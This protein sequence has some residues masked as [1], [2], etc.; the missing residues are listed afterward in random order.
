MNEIRLR[1]VVV[2][3]GDP[4]PSVS[5]AHGGF[6]SWF[7]RSL[8][9]EVE[10][11]LCDAR[12][13]TP[14][15]AWLDGCTGLVL[16]GSPH[17][18]YEPLPW[19]AP[20]EELL[21]DAVLSR[22]MPTLGVC[23]GHQLLA[24]AL[25]GRVIRNPR[26]REMGT[27]MVQRHDDVAVLLDGLGSRFA[28]QAT[29]RDTVVAPPRDAVVHAYS[30]RDDCQAFSVGTA[31]GVQFHPE[32]TAPILR[33]YIQARA[34]VLRTEGVDPQDLH[35]AVHDTVSGPI[36]FRNFLEVVRDEARARVTPWPAG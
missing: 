33:S 25:G 19:I 6:A 1:C 35:D 15:P 34:G 17:S 30:D 21:R 26:G 10:V 28:A 16:T 3:C 36:V 7:L 29:H 27:I 20:L 24:Q 5:A 9:P 18:V 23:F 32:V 22:R 14:A 12:C 11:R 2:V 4:D 13:E 31:F 8:G